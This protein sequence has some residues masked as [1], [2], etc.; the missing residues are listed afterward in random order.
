M[1]RARTGAD[2]AGT[3]RAPEP[4]RRLEGRGGGRRRVA[5]PGGLVSRGGGGDGARGAGRDRHHGIESPIIPP[6]NPFVERILAATYEAP[7][8][9][10]RHGGDPKTRGDLWASVAVMGALAGA[11]AGLPILDP[12]GALIVACFIG[13][14]G[15]QIARATTRIL[16]DQVVISEADLERV[17][18][19]VPGVIGCEK[20]RTRGS[21]DHVFLDLHVW[22]PPEMRLTEAHERS[23]EPVVVDGARGRQADGGPVFGPQWT[24]AAQPPSPGR[25]EGD[26]SVQLSGWMLLEA[27]AVLSGND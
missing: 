17:V 2:R 19:S 21:A 9:H 13:H 26:L 12:L 6:L 14:A 23:S 22:M 11:R 5:R 1:V 7:P 15:L 27:A 10:S 16:S 25:P 8:V 4:A 18:M 20:I 3:R 24:V